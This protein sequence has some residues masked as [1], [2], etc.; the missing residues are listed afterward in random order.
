MLGAATTEGRTKQA[1]PA[2][3]PRPAAGN[4]FLS[5]PTYPA[6]TPP[7]CC[8]KRLS[9]PTRPCKV[10]VLQQENASCG[11]LARILLD[12]QKPAKGENNQ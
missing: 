5:K 8:W 6:N 9:K 4:W 7:S 3:N 10:P 1:H 11:T 12:I 2:N